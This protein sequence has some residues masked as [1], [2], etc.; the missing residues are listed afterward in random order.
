MANLQR[1]M[2]KPRFIIGN[3]GKFGRLQPFNFSTVFAGE[4]QKEIK[5]QLSFMSEP[6]N[7]AQSG[8]TVDVWFYY[9]PFSLVWD[10]WQ[11]WIMGD[12]TD[13]LSYSDYASGRLLW[14]K[15]GSD[16][17]QGLYA[18]QDHMLANAYTMVANHYF[19]DDEN[20]LTT[21][22]TAPVTLPI[23][24]Q[25]AETSGDVDLEDEDETIDV[26]SGTL[27]LKELERKRATLRYERRV[28]MMDG[29][30]INW[31]KNQG[32]NANETLAEI[33]EFLGHYRRYIKPSRTV[34][35]SNGFT[36]QH[37]GH[38][39]KIKL[40]KRRYFQEAGV[41]IGVYSVRPKVHI[42]GGQDTS[43]AMFASPQQFPQVGQLAEH[44]RVMASA[45]NNEGGS[46]NDPTGTPSTY[47][48]IDAS[49]FKG[50][51]QA[52]NVDSDYIKS[53]NPT[54]DASAMYPI[55]AWDN[56][57]VT[58]QEVHYAVDGVMSHSLV[59]PLRKL[60]PA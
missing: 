60:L 17:D 13:T 46:E 47:M 58:S 55:T 30:Y 3:T 38:E 16:D 42:I 10:N 44:K 43:A 57:L 50:R 1:Q 23:V 9:V 6:I 25:S 34:D 7:V 39:C 56:M 27:S 37:Y 48:S 51:H 52:F 24:D 54:D 8:A 26:S 41:V 36:V 2:R 59:T 18:Q 49:L 35:Q 22:P 12:T 32:V 4:T 45:G 53:H 19:R 11:T 15:T 29:K 14:G 21:V 33:P 20:Q 5:A 31:L 28:E 40:T